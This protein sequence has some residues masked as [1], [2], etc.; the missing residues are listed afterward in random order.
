MFWSGLRSDKLL[1]PGGCLAAV[2]LLLLPGAAAA[3]T[4]TWS[5]QLIDT[6]GTD[7]SLVV[8]RDG[9]VH[10]SYRFLTKSQL[11][12]AF[13]PSGGS[14]WFT[15]SLDQMLGDF[16]SRITVDEKGNPY[17]CYTPKVLKF[18]SFDGRRWTTQ[19]VDPGGG[20]VN[21]YCSV[22]VG[23]DGSPQVSW[24]VESGVF[25]RYAILKD[26]V[27]TAQNIDVQGTPGKFNS[28]ILD[29]H[30][31][32]HV[33]YISLL[34]C[35]L[36]YAHYDGKGWI[37]STLDASDL[38]PLGGDRGMG[39]S[40]TLDRQGNPMISY[41]DSQSLKF[42]HLVNGKWKLETLDHFPQ[43]TLWGWR[44][45]RSNI[46]LDRDGNPHIGYE[47]ILG[48]K[49]AWWD[50]SIWKTQLILAPAGTTFDGAMDID[51]NNNLY[52]SYTDPVDRSLKLAIGRFTP[53]GE[54]AQTGKAAPANN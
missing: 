36:K 8:D 9:N 28:M 1:G 10:V 25:L 33:S 26:G 20:V 47:S 45:F 40:I 18:A 24:Y 3:Q 46:V 31:N 5:T 14:Q 27:W 52:F 11:K 6:E 32:P 42:A 44:N 53:A 29:A 2:A 43:I 19:A 30:G 49:H 17:I 48:L 41:F 15:M 50:G 38:S 34:G 22:R 39:N 4:W 51:S 13:L 16:Q 7:S 37:R 35:K 21:Y 12:Y 23:A 54:T